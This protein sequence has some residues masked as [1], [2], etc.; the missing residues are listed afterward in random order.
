M[1]ASSRQRPQRSA[2][3]GH[4]RHAASMQSGIAGK[5]A[6]R[7][8]A[9][10]AIRAIDERQAFANLLLPQMLAEHA[11]S[12]QNARFATNLVYGTLRQRG[13]LD[14]V[15]SVAARRPCAKIDKPV[16]NLLRCGVFEALFMATPAYAVPSAYVDIAKRRRMRFE[17]GF[18]NAVLRTVSA[19]N[20]DEWE[21]SVLQG[22]TDDANRLA[23]RYSHPRWIID[24]FARSLKAAYGTV[25]RHQ[26]EEI[27]AR[28]NAPAPVTLVLH[29]IDDVSADAVASCK[30]KIAARLRSHASDARFSGT[31]PGAQPEARSSDGDEHVADGL[32]SPCALRVSGIDIAAAVRSLNVGVEDEGSQLAA[33]TL[34]R[35]IDEQSHGHHDDERCSRQRWLDLC[36]A[37]GGKTALL[38]IAAAHRGARV[39]ANEIYPQ[40]AE[41]VR[42]NLQFL[43]RR[44]PQT[45]EAITV[46]DG[47]EYGA[48][49][50]QVGL[51][52]AI[53]VDAPC[54][55]LGTLRR[56][57]E[58]RWRKSAA[59]VRGL[60]LLQ[61]ELLTSALAVLKPGGVCAYV[62]CSPAVEETR[63]VVDAVLAQDSHVHRQDAAGVL[64]RVCPALPLPCA[65][66]GA[67]MP[68]DVQLFEAPHDTDM[69]F[70]SLLTRD[71]P[72]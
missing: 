60:A 40:R 1:V 43:R 47:R 71:Y 23:I 55:G 27:C 72:A 6:A 10:D 9:V 11:V 17:T 67:V 18:I 26:L 54:S 32:W 30:R 16:L 53:L 50:E 45:I 51:F 56:R 46:R 62:T 39:T 4:S 41:L 14:A 37:P 29:D 44:S 28:D 35:A 22:E 59:D 2:A 24:E 33:L 12:G 58:A 61:K 34:I 21:A 68:G 64:H 19:R 20:L 48:H 52:D 15:I 3:P 42:Q 66:D 38:A 57:P 8:V 25:N 65:P 63:D 31:Q 7:R 69:M 5:K 49:R 36:A 13:F 70:I